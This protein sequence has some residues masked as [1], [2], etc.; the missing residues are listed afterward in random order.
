MGLFDEIFCEYPLPEGFEHLQDKVF[1]TKDL[2]NYMT[3][4]VIKKDGGLY[5]RI[6]EVEDIPE[7]EVDTTV[8]FPVRHRRTGKVTDT[9]VTKLHDMPIVGEVHGDIHFY[10]STGSRKTNDFHWYD[11]VARFNDGKLKWIKVIED[12]G[13]G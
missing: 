8:I 4:Y 9:L 6:Y 1:Q 10:T 13:T 5:Q 11:F 3:R 2:D 7:D 12:A